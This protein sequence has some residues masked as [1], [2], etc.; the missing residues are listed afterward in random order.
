M[1]ANHLSNAYE[2]LV[3]KGRT[4]NFVF[5]GGALADIN[6]LSS[7]FIYAKEHGLKLHGVVVNIYPDDCDESF[8]NQIMCLLDDGEYTLIPQDYRDMRSLP[9]PIKPFVRLR[10][11]LRSLRM[12]KSDYPYSQEKGATSEKEQEPIFLLYPEAGYVDSGIVEYLL[13]LGRPII[14]VP[15]DEGTGSYVCDAYERMRSSLWSIANPVKRLLVSLELRMTR[16]FNDLLQD[17]LKSECQCLPFTIFKEENGVVVPNSF[18]QEYFRKAFYELA[19]RRQT[20]HVDYSRSILIVGTSS[21]AF[22]IEEIELEA[23]ESVIDATHGSEVEL[24]FR[25][26]PRVSDLSR[27]KKLPISIDEHR[28]YSMEEL[29]AVSDTKPLATVGLFSSGQINANALW[30]VPAVSYGMAMRQRFSDEAKENDAAGE[31]LKDLDSMNRL[32]SNY[33]MFPSDRDELVSIIQS[34][35]NG[36]E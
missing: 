8:H 22:G 29:L 15:L 10:S 9:M 16:R 28:D 31:I 24:L 1:R 13:G 17:K 20:P 12:F 7:F 32:F 25:P 27:Y 4:P 5:F 14:Y 34:F 33:M 35:N 18:S 36:V 3:E 19:M 26:H 30:N 6:P 2:S 21:S 11:T 23:I